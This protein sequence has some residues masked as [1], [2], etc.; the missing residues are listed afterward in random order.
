MN[1]STILNTTEITNGFNTGNSASSRAITYIVLQL[2][3]LLSLPAYLFVGFHLVTNTNLRQKL[4]NHAI[5]VLLVFNF[6]VLTIDMSFILNFLRSGVIS[7]S[8]NI[9]C[10][11]WIFIDICMYNGSNLLMCWVSIERRLLIF[12]MNWLNTRKRRF[13]LHYL[14][15][16]S[17][18][19]YTLVYYIYV[20][21]FYSCENDFNFT[22]AFC[23]Y[24]CYILQPAPNLFT[25]ENL[26][27][28]VAPCFIIV[29][30]S[31]AL[32]A[33]TLL[34]KCVRRQMIVWR[35]YKKMTV[36]LLTILLVYL[37]F[38]FPYT[39]NPLAELINGSQPIDDAIQINALGYWQYGTCFLLPYA[40]SISIPNSRNKL[41]RLVTFR[42][43][44]VAPVSVNNH[45]DH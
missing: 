10:L 6:I 39:I 19:T 18:V 17:V 31:A 7:P 23:G 12:H 14:P 45:L 25:I 2:F 35:R 20:V 5:L 4:S 33:R 42:R 3:Q 41:R 24:P 44:T 34:G 26:L 21:F 27:H 9:T 1:I 30:F 15:L 37:I 32:L 16:A 36:H 11:I 13:F 40:V 8:T 29:G 28:Q 38:I 43:R 22:F